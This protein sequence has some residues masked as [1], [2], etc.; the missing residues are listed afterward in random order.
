MYTGSISFWRA[1]IFVIH[2][3]PPSHI[4]IYGEILGYYSIPYPSSKSKLGW[5][6]WQV[7]LCLIW[8][9]W[10]NTWG[11]IS[12]SSLDQ[13]I[14]FST[15]H[16]GYHL[17]RHHV[18]WNIA[19]PLD[20]SS[21]ARVHLSIDIKSAQKA[22]WLVLELLLSGHHDLLSQLTHC[23][24]LETALGRDEKPMAI[25][26]RTVLRSWYSVAE[27]AQPR[28]KRRDKRSGSIS[29]VLYKYPSHSQSGSKS[30]K[31]FHDVP[32]LMQSSR[33]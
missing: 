5:L 26:Y 28:L 2:V 13:L 16:F 3:V 20:K 15:P 12:R 1:W 21:M 32:L 24:A 6:Q 9:S 4:S 19:F 14:G 7:G 11:I 23:F 10:T 29:T 30:S 31:N 18:S 33:S 25:K 22:Q 17:G 8:S 27:V